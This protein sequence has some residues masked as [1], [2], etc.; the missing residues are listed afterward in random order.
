MSKNHL[1]TLIIILFLLSFSLVYA[2]PIQG[3]DLQSCSCTLFSNPITIK[4]QGS[5]IDSFY[6]TQQGDAAEWSTV[7]PDMIIIEPGQTATVENLINL[8]CDVYGDYFLKTT[9]VSSAKTET[10]VQKLSIKRCSNINAVFKNLTQTACNCTP[11]EFEFRLKNTGSYN[12]IYSM[13]IL[14]GVGSAITSSVNPIILMPGD[15]QDV[16]LYITPPRDVFGEFNTTFRI[17][18]QN[19]KFYADAPLTLNIKACPALNVSGNV[20]AQPKFMPGLKSLLTLFII[21][22]AILF[23]MVITYFAISAREEPYYKPIKIKEPEISKPGKARLVAEKFVKGNAFKTIIALIA[24][25]IVAFLIYKGV[26]MIKPATPLN[27]TNLTINQTL[28]I[29][30]NITQQKNQ[31]SAE[32]LDLKPYF[33]YIYYAALGFAILFLLILIRIR[34]EQEPVKRTKKPK[35][36]GFNIIDKIRK[37]LKIIVLL[38]LILLI[39]CLGHYYRTIIIPY[40]ISFKEYVQMYLVYI[41]IGFVMLAA[42][43]TVLSR[44][45]K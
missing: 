30:E 41:I 7:F 22:L 38:F 19:S 24:L 16:K 20:T 31:T 14:D 8:P 27:E 17:T 21:L 12:E 32:K 11:F 44:I 36:K 42:L 2:G 9:V 25:I 26:Q 29:T 1:F 23:L 15:T 5:S 45:R 10:I 43:L 33:S 37:N 6:I 39:A 3:N 28:N 13:K 4:N 35:I 34:I 40:L 18:A